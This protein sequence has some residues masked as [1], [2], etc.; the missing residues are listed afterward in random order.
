MIPV[1]LGE[2][3]WRRVS[4]NEQNNVD[5]LRADLDMVQEYAKRPESE[6]KPLSSGRSEDTIPGYVEE[7]S[8]KEIWCGEKSEKP[9][10]RDKKANLQQIGMTP[11]G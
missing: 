9:V 5:N 7:P 6:Q 10:G 8:K 1:E 3:S 11:T 4:F 2:A